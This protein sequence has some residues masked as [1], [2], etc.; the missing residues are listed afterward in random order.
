MKPTWTSGQFNGPSSHLTLAPGL[1]ISVLYP[2]ISGEKGY[3]VRFANASLKNR[4]E[5]ENEAKKAGLGLAARVLKQAQQTLDALR[6]SISR[7]IFHEISKKGLTQIKGKNRHIQA[8]KLVNQAL[9]REYPDADLDLPGYFWYISRYRR[10][11]KVGL[12][13][14]TPL[15][16]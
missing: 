15:D 10:Q 1:V 7:I 3:K 14:P 8:L 16:A 12:A 6:P 2:V 13:F 11:K 9:K 4:I 5:D